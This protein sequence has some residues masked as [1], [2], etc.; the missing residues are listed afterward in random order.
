MASSSLFSSSADFL[1]VASAA[2]SCAALL[3]RVLSDLAKRSWLAGLGSAA[4]SSCSFSKPSMWRAT[5]ARS[6]AKGLGPSA[7]SGRM[8]ISVDECWCLGWLAAPLAWVI[9][10]IRERDQK[11]PAERYAVKD[12]FHNYILD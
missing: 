8:V 1:G 11:V 3:I 10:P 5:R 9:N 12:Y 2:N 7:S 6:A 4:N